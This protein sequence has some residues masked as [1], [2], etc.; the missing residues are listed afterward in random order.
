MKKIAVFLAAALV[1]AS[2]FATITGAWNSFVIVNSQ[3][4]DASGDSQGAFNKFN[5]FNLGELTSLTLGGEVTLWTDDGTAWAEGWSG[6]VL[7]YAIAQNGARIGDAQTVTLST[8]SRENDNFKVQ[9]DPGT[10]I[11]A[12]NDLPAGN[13]EL[14]V[15]FGM[16]NGW[17]PGNN[18]YY[19]ANF[20]K[21]D[22]P[23]EV[24]EPA[25][26][27]LLGLGALALA[28]RRKLRK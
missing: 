6:G 15:W 22:S 21:A 18:G 13:Y 20:T 19:H 14:Q 17:D 27:S 24:P 26:M 1:A 10:A 11:A 25:T 23:A 12:F 28:L 9:S 4:Y 2:A 3:W 16:D 7:G 8:V 5:D